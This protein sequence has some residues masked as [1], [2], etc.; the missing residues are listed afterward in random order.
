MT[1]ARAV[2]LKFLVAVAAVHIAAIAIYYALDIPSMPSL[3]QRY[4]AWGWMAVTVAVV[5]A[6]LHRL[7]R[8]RRGL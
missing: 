2:F 5:F 3:R 7:R 6:G 1:P 8:A 4:F